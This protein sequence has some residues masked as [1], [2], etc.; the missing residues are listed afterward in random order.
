VEISNLNNPHPAIEKERYFTPDV[1][2][3]LAICGMLLVN[4]YAYAFPGWEGTSA[5]EYVVS[6]YDNIA[7]MFT[8]V[9][10]GGKFLTIFSVLFGLGLALQLSN[11]HLSDV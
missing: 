11:G 4:I 9:F 6:I 1:L 8:G 10:L 7:L 2:R 3:G 5:E